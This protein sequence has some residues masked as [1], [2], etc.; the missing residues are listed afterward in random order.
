MR[1][2]SREGPE[3]LV[4]HRKVAVGRSRPGGR[5]DG[6]RSGERPAGRSASSSSRWIDPAKLGWYSGDHHIHAAGCAHYNDPTQGVLAFRH[7]GPLPRRR[8]QSRLQSHLGAPALT[9]R[10]SSSPAPWTRFPATRTCSATT[11]KSPAFG[12]HQS[13]HPGPAGPQAADLP[14]RRLRPA[15]A[16]PRPQH[17]EVGQ[18]PGGRQ[19]PQRIPAGAWRLKTKGPSQLRNSSLRRPLG[20]TSTSW[21]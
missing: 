6:R 13:G 15:L 21:T 4:Q 16:D 3:Y 9:T 8:P 11:S 1:S 18:G 12:S 19:R 2:K 5:A 14:R 17:A 7:D 20:P 10:S